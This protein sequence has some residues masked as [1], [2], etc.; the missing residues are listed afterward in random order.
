MSDIHTPQSAF[1]VDHSEDQSP[2]RAQ[3]ARGL[4]QHRARIVGEAESGHDE[5]IVE[6]AVRAG[7]SLADGAGDADAPIARVS[8]HLQYG[9]DAEPDPKRRGE[10][11][12]ADPDLE[13]PPLPRQQGELLQSNETPFEGYPQPANHIGGIDVFNG[14][15]FVGAENFKDGVGKD[16][17][18]AIHDAN[19]LK[20]KRAFSFEASSGQQEAH[21]VREKVFTDVKRQGEIE[22]G[23][24]DP[25]TGEFLVVYNRGARIILGMPKGFYPGYDHEIYRYKMTS[26]SAN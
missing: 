13:S 12:G 26:F 1:A 10:A 6:R 22:A 21:V 18:I 2:T 11:P 7:Q 9:V 19:T 8:E 3:H 17:Q 23:G 14:E 25:K 15:I 4:A 24:V 16:I 20:L 5:R